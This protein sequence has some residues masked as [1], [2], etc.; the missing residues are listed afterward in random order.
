MSLQ[1]LWSLCL[2]YPS[3]VVN[4]LALFLALAGAWLLLAT[5]RR[6]Q[7]AAARLLLDGE[8]STLDDADL[9]GDPQVERLNRF[10]YRF[11]AVSLLAALLLSWLSTRLQGVAAF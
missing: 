5:R 8:L 4:G 2:S 6:E 7:G 9:A 10:F 11:G 1:L 3:Q